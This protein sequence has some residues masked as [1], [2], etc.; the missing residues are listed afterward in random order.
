MPYDSVKITSLMDQY[1]DATSDN[2]RRSY[3]NNL[4]IE[5]VALSNEDRISFIDSLK[6]KTENNDIS[7]KIFEETDIVLFKD[8]FKFEFQLF[9]KSYKNNYD[10]WEKNKLSIEDFNRVQSNLIYLWGYEKS[11]SFD[12]WINET[13]L[14]PDTYYEKIFQLWN[15]ETPV[16]CRWFA[17]QSIL[18]LKSRVKE[19]LEQID[20]YTKITVK[21]FSARKR[22][23]II[24]DIRLICSENKDLTNV[25]AQLDTLITE[26]KI[27]TNY[28]EPKSYPIE[29][30]KGVW[31]QLSTDQKYPLPKFIIMSSDNIFQA[32][33]SNGFYWNL[34]NL[35]LFGII[36]LIGCLRGKYKQINDS[37][38]VEVEFTKNGSRL[39]S[40]PKTNLFE[41]MES[42][43]SGAKWIL[44]IGSGKAPNGPVGIR[45]ELQSIYVDHEIRIDGGKQFDFVDNSGKILIEGFSGTIFI[46]EKVI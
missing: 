2:E 12:S 14:N 42:I 15:N 22:E 44:S 36:P 19:T 32:V 29:K 33:S 6:L 3:L 24:S 7:L 17:Y 4:V 26:L 43:E 39:F 35:S 31:R 38:S 28:E 34:S 1:I 10:N 25:R 9:F 13:Y 18:D 23:D 8:M 11:Y 40:L 37:A 30:V 21:T 5:Y 46:L 45:G 41:F 20:S 27:S 16:I